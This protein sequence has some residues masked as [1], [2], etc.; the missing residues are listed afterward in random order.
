MSSPPPEAPPPPEKL[1]LKVVDGNAAGT[2][3]EVEDELVIGREAD[4]HGALASDVEISRRHARIAS[5]ADGSFVIE[6]LESTNG[7]YVNG[8]RLEGTATLETGDRIELGASALVVQFSNLQPTPTDSGTIAPAPREA[9]PAEPTPPEQEAPPANE[10]EPVAPEPEPVAPEPEPVAPEP[11]VAVP[12]SFA[13]R[14]EV[15][16]E[17][18]KAVVSLDEA[19]DEVSLVYEDGR[20]R[21]S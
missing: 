16:L 14:I 20:W 1:R 15:D 7:T 4:G 19:S 17:G 13:I 6:D 21:L 9:E 12:P 2:L 3:I 5:E 10:T 8:R 11:Q 18:G